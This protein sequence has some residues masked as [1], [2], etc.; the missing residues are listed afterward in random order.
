MDNPTPTQPLTN[1]TD[2]TGTTT[3]T[4]PASSSNPPLS[5]IQDLGSSSPPS[6]KSSPLMP[7][8]L[9]L[10]VIVLAV[11]GGYLAYDKFLLSKQS[12]PTS[13]EQCL[14]TKGSLI[15]ESY[16]QVCVT[17]SGQHFVQPLPSPSPSRMVPG[18]Y[19][20]TKY[21]YSFDY[22]NNWKLNENSIIAS[23]VLS[24]VEL[25]PSGD[26]GETIKLFIE[27][28][29]LEGHIERFSHATLLERNEFTL[30]NKQGIKETYIPQ[31]TESTYIAVTLPLEADMTLSIGAPKNLEREFDLILQTFRF[32]DNETN[33]VTLK[34]FTD[35]KHGYSLQ[36]P[37]ETFIQ[38]ICPGNEAEKF[39][40]INKQ[41]FG[42]NQSEPFK[43]GGCDR[44]S[45]YPLEISVEAPTDLSFATNEY[46]AVET[47]NI[48]VANTSATKKVYTQ[49]K[50]YAA[51]R[52]FAEISIPYQGKTYQIILAEKSQEAVFTQLLQTFQ[53]IENPS[54]L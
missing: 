40:L 41:S 44:D 52:W 25:T 1:I 26:I 39:I 19:T 12:Q 50:P 36:Y 31:G 32:L 8:L 11:G 2:L 20:N 35:T 48:Q 54:K 34:T 22:P 29:S 17:K 9:G 47:Q 43:M 14:T 23:N 6:K 3:T 42:K 30:K 45:F 5:K 4:L 21:K 53:F 33:Q 10:I 24:S 15:Q 27:P 7:T 13:Y 28:I 46:Y 49:I 18:T 51:S 38:I 37:T 16:P